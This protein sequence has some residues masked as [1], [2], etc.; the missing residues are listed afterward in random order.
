MT[1]VGMQEANL[2]LLADEATGA[3]LLVD[4]GGFIPALVELVAERGI[5]VGHILITHLH[6]DHVDA[7]PRYL[8][9][10]PDAAVV[11]PAAPASA[12][13]VRIVGEGDRIEVGPF[14][15]AVLELPGHTPESIAYHCASAGV[16]FVG[17]AIFAG[18]V[19]GTADDEKFE[20]QVGHLKRKIMTLPETTELLSGHGPLTT[21]AI[22]R[23]ANPFLQPGFGRTA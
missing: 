23:R 3:G 1:E 6:Y 10:W 14:T 17:D 5:K 15:F 18:A 8:E 19:G 7:L 16:C 12:P 13:R 21:V 20:Q 2:H 22:E 11:A 4:A 9:Q